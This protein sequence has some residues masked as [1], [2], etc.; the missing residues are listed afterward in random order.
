M[1]KK[2]G[3][4][5]SKPIKTP[6]SSETKL[7]RNEDGESVDD[8]KYHGMIGSL[9]YL[10]ASRS[11]I[12]FSVCLCARFQEAPK[13]S[14]LEAVKRIFRYIKGTNHLGLWYP[15]GT[16]VETIIYADSDHAGDYVDRKS[17]SD[18]CT[19]MGCCLTSWFSKKQTALAFS[20]TEAEYVFAKK[21]CQQALWMKQ[22]LVDYNIVLDDIPILCDNKGAIDLSKN[23]VLHS[24]IKHIKTVIT[25]FVTMFKKGTSQLRRTRS[26]GTQRL[27]RAKVHT[28]NIV[29]SATSVVASSLQIRSR[30]SSAKGTGR[31]SN[32]VQTMPKSN[33]EKKPASNIKRTVRISIRPCCFSNPHPSSP[34]YQALSPTTNYQMAPPSSPNVSSPLSPVTTPGISQSK[35]L[36]TPKSS[37]PPLTSPPPA[38]T[39]PSKHSS[40]LT[41]KLDPIELIFLTPPTSPRAFFDSLEDLPP[42]TTNPPPP[43]P[44]F[45]SI[46]RLAN[47]P[48]P[49]LAME[50]PLPPLPP[51][52][53]PL[54]PQLPPIGPNNPFPML[55]H[56]MLCDHWQCT[57]VIVDT[58]RDE[59]RFI[60]NHILY[61]L[62]VLAYNY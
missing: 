13:T 3:L 60:P 10:T 33:K 7:T 59:I 58:L 22:A 43:R 25:S 5:D 50:P 42:R 14:H 37:P 12:M 9:L 27:K 47:Q 2:Y 21:A 36:L 44:S 24:H 48:P 4:E 53:P 26:H 41:I 19:F 40:P 20:T 23:P 34:P 49:L 28:R 31:I 30:F 55:T 52:L 18:V 29:S 38:P 56:E 1:F 6:R 61:R 39:Q 62:N 11:D 15:K 16:G 8:T 32:T 51:Q 57:Q 54:P 17:T 45:E 46:E 35:L